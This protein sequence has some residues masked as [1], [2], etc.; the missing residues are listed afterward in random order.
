MINSHLDACLSRGT[1]RK[2]TQ[3]TLLQFN[4]CSQSMA[5]F[6]TGGSKKLR[7]DSETGATNENPLQNSAICNENSYSVKENDSSFG[8]LCVTV[9]TILGA[10]T[11]VL[12]KKPVNG[13]GGSTK[14]PGNAD[15][16]NCQ[17]HCS[18]LSLETEFSKKC[19]LV[20]TVD[21]VVGVVL[22]T[23]I[24]GRRFSLER[25]LRLGA[26]ISLLRDPNNAKDPNAIKVCFLFL[27]RI[28]CCQ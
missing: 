9:E 27:P 28:L 2:L 12:T 13:T 25:D 5:Q 21:D 24:V 3:R 4:F 14:K 10:S 6:S 19:D 26:R 23:L 11:G 16:K 18:S 15:L 8:K 7:S 1:K 22:G 20:I 17:V